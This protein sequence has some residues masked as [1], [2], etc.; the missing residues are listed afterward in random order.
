[1]S[2]TN[3]LGIFLAILAVAATMLSHGANPQAFISPLGF[4]LVLGG[5]CAYAM[6]SYPFDLVQQAIKAVFGITMR[7]K[8]D[9]E[10]LKRDVERLVSWSHFIQSKGLKEFEKTVASKLTEPLLRYGTDLL[11]SNY[12]PADIRRLMETAAE[13]TFDRRTRPVSVLRNMSGSAPAFGM[14]GTLVGMI[15]MLGNFESDMSKIGSGMAVA[16]LSTFYGL[17]L[18][19]LVFM[20]AADNLMMKEDHVLFRNY[21]LAEGLALIAEKRNPSFVQDALDSYMDPLHHQD[22]V[23][24]KGKRNEPII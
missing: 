21:I 4:S 6:M 14:V 11:V 16:M 19:R 10:K 8:V 9:I 15:I 7:P 1:M 12:N 2:F 13:A 23:H 3:I 17:I 20:P 18:S 24:L 22:L 5:S